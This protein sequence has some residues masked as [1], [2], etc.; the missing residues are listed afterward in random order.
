M[1]FQFIRSTLSYILFEK[2]IS[3][4]IR[5]NLE[6][7]RITEEWKFENFLEDAR[8]HFRSRGWA[9]HVIEAADSFRAASGEEGKKKKTEKRENGYAIAVTWPRFNA[10]LSL[11]DSVYRAGPA[12][13]RRRKKYIYI[14]SRIRQRR[15]YQRR[16]GHPGCVLGTSLQPMVG[17]SLTL[18]TRHALE[19]LI[20]G[21]HFHPFHRRI[22]INITCI[23]I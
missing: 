19:A 1:F 2:K 20:I 6:I 11:D 7:S 10:E 4:K 12:R 5:Q 17:W 15:F 13:R 18:A 21:L 16:C 14:R 3:T 22:Y 23:N 8:C 9:A